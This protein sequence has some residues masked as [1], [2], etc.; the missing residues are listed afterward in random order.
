M[1]VV[2]VKANMLHSEKNTISYLKLYYLARI[3]ADV[4]VW[5]LVAQ[6]LHFI[7]SVAELSLSLSWGGA[8]TLLAA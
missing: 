4:L 3:R 2:Q 5:L 1:S 7:G 8:A 6:I